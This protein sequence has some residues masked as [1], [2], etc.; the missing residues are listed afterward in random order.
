MIISIREG[1][2]NSHISQLEKAPSG[3][4]RM[5]CTAYAKQPHPKKQVTCERQTHRTKPHQ[6]RQ[7][8]THS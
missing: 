5:P 1:A 7:K 6:Q 4:L 8:K 2:Q 3:H